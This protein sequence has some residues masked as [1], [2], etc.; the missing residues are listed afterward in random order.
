ML[1]LQPTTTRVHSR[2]IGLSSDCRNSQ[3]RRRL[4]PPADPTSHGVFTTP[5]S[6][7]QRRTPRAPA[8]RLRLPRSRGNDGNALVSFDLA[9]INHAPLPARL[10][11][12]PPG[13]HPLKA[14]IEKVAGRTRKAA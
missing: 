3:A 12:G 2:R 13:G 6:K 10:S 11:A 9:E 1:I 8:K 7:S 4:A 14:K 5:D